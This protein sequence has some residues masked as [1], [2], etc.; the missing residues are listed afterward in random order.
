MKKEKNAVLGRIP[1][2]KG[3]DKYNCILDSA[4]SLF[5]IHGVAATTISQI[6]QQSNVTSA[7]VHYYFQNRD[8]LL[9]HVV[10]ERLAP[11]MTNVW[12]SFDEKNLVDPIS[13]ITQ[14][15]N[16]L[17]DVVESMPELPFLWNKEI[18]NLGGLLREPFFAIIPQKKIESLVAFFISA[19]K[20][21]MINSKIAPNLIFPSIIATVMV[22]L[23]AQNFTHEIPIVKISNKEILRQHVISLILN[24][25]LP[26]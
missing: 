3:E 26:H 7:M 8:G 16:S 5:A 21:G 12:S 14:L 24:G 23:I 6:A 20:K 22:P 11:A 13:I 17:F 15:I 19:Q 9:Q 18:L 2:S 1:L 4:L 10:T 25:I